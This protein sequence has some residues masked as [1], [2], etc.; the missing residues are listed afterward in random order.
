M[1]VPHEALMELWYRALDAEIGIAIPSDKCA[2]LSR[3]L[4]EARGRTGDERLM[5]LTMQQPAKI[6]EI[7]ICHKA[8]EIPEE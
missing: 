3:E 6:G 8:I 4:Y 2:Q 7:W 1:P 5:T